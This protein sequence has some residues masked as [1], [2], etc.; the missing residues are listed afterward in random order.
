[1]SSSDLIWRGANRASADI[2]RVLLAHP[3]IVVAPR[4]II[5]RS[6]CSNG[7]A[8]AGGKAAGADTEIETRARRRGALLHAEQVARNP[9]RAS[10]QIGIRA[11]QTG[12][13]LQR[14]ELIGLL[15]ICECDLRLLRNG[16]GAGPIV[17]RDRIE[18]SVVA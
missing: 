12:E 6:P 13:A 18:R 2:P 9:E 16:C 7:A 8:D 11:V 10:E 15:F 3:A 17:A 4:Q 1:M 14:G 5:P